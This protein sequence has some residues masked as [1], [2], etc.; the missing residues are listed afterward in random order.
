MN[1]AA[2]STPYRPMGIFSVAGTRGPLFAPDAPTGGEG[3]VEGGNPPAG[4]E[5]N[6]ADNGVGKITLAQAEYD[7]LKAAA[8]QAEALKGVEG[9][10]QAAKTA[11]G[12]GGSE[13]QRQAAVIA[14]MLAAGHSDEEIV[15]ALGGEEEEEESPRGKGK[16]VQQDPEIA[17]RLQEL[18]ED[19]QQDR[20]ERLREK[21]EQ[22]VEQVF[23]KGPLSELLDIM[24]EGL[25]PEE[26]K[27]L[28][29]T[30]R[31]DV[32]QSSREIL[33]QR[34][35]RE[36]QFQTSWIPDAVKQAA[37]KAAKKARLFGGGSKIGRAGELSPA[38]DEF[39]KQ[40]A[41]KL[42]HPLAAGDGEQALNEFVADSLT[43]AALQGAS[44]GASK[45]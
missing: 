41:K 38:E 42:P 23:A 25:K 24:K 1:E 45:A 18:A 26:L 10:A 16:G 31:E 12:K 30:L 20:L 39:L 40:P 8:D 2:P 3:T 27:A 34:R 44:A 43:R 5:K 7:K 21:H 32:V 6:P 17:R 4:G 35:D 11:F 9:L 14:L 13:E 33:R 28:Q 37:D 29:D 15:E 22:S 36:G 19:T